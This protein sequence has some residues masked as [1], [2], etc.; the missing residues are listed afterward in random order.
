M[1]FSS[2]F[3]SK[4]FTNI[5]IQRSPFEMY[6]VTISNVIDRLVYKIY[7]YNR[8]SYSSQTNLLKVE[9]F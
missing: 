5:F 2:G 9:I 3:N 7:M 6:T 1:N 4:M 8:L